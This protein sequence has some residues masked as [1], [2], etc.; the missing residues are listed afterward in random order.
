MGSAGIDGRADFGAGVDRDFSPKSFDLR[1]RHHLFDDGVPL[2][3]RHTLEPSW[4]ELSSGI[5]REHFID[6]L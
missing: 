6:V 2:V 5:T 4:L 1:R 3:I